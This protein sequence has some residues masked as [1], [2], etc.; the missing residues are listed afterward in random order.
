MIMASIS[1]IMITA[2]ADTILGQ[3]LWTSTWMLV[4]AIAARLLDSTIKEE[5]EI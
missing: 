4:F 2:E 3:I 1:F 5:E